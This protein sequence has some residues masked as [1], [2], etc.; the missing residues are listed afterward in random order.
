VVKILVVVV[1]GKRSRMCNGWR[2]EL[3]LY[4]EKGAGGRRSLPPSLCSIR[5][6]S[7]RKGEMKNLRFEAPFE[8]L[9]HQNIK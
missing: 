9:Y 1:L 4:M 7:K 3:A 2:R 6:R 5:R 8:L